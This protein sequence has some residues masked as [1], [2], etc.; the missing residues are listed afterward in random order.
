MQQ[1]GAAP[2]HGLYPA[3]HLLTA[4]PV[5]FR[6]MAP[7]GAADAAVELPDDAPRAN[8]GIVV[9]VVAAVA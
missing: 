8:C 4:I 1:T 3:Q 6:T 9:C 5:A 2:A 7:P